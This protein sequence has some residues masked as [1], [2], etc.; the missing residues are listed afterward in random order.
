M[1]MTTSSNGIS[2]FFITPFTY[3]FLFITYT[4]FLLSFTTSRPQ[5]GEFHL[6]FDPKICIDHLSFSL[7]S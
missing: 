6:C 5:V 1:F 7:T 4:P 3:C 2:K